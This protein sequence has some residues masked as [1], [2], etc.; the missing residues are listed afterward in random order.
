MLKIKIARSP[1]LNGFK[2]TINSILQLSEEL[3]TQY[4]NPIL[5]TRQL[6]QDPLENLF[7]TTRQQHGC[8]VNP[9][10]K[11]FETALRHI[12]ITQLSKLSNATNCEEDDNKIFAKLSKIKSVLTPEKIDI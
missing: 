6:N 9:S 7:A 4:D 3:R 10:P 11:Q 8:S 5:K 1:C 2:I 12:F